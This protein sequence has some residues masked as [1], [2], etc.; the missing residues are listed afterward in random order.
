MACNILRRLTPCCRVIYNLRHSHLRTPHLC[1]CA[2]GCLTPALHCP[3]QALLPCRLLCLP[4]SCFCRCYRAL[5]L[6]GSW[7]R[8]LWLFLLLLLQVVSL[9][10]P[11]DDLESFLPQILEGILLWAEDSKN[12]FRAKVGREVGGVVRVCGLLCLLLHS[13]LGAAVWLAHWQIGWSFNWLAGW[14]KCERDAS[15]MDLT[16][17]TSLRLAS[18]AYGYLLCFALASMLMLR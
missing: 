10:L 5:I 1:S 8:C 13:G 9:R 7:I 2:A 6:P 17:W 18:S 11:A 14:F 4:P 15:A 16:R 12:K 3:L